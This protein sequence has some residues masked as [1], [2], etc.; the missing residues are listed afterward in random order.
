ME[1]ST[2]G[3]VE[4][5]GEV[6]DSTYPLLREGRL[7]KVKCMKPSFPQKPRC[8]SGAQD[9]LD[10]LGEEAVRLVRELR[11]LYLAPSGSRGPWQG[12]KPPCQLKSSLPPPHQHWRRV[13]WA[14]LECGPRRQRGHRLQAGTGRRETQPPPGD[15][16]GRRQGDAPRRD[17][18]CLLGVQE[19]AE[20]SRRDPHAEGRPGGGRAEAVGRPADCATGRTLRFVLWKHELDPC[21]T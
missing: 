13:S 21:L 1:G 9:P 10:H 3:S 18:R 14:S 15:V 8:W 19:G 12:L 11:G 4:E 5:A 20:V 16:E 17:V 2:P 6:R 7:A